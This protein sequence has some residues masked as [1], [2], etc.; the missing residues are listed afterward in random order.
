M[1]IYTF[2]FVESA[3]FGAHCRQSLEPFPGICLHDSNLDPFPGVAH[4]DDSCKFV[5]SDAS[6]HNLVS[7]LAD[8][9][10][11]LTLSE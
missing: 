10:S 8:D 6:P 11:R 4:H 1:F 7:Y 9:R 5:P 2:I 3:F